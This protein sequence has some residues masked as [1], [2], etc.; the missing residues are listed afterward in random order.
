MCPPCAKAQMYTAGHC[1]LCRAICGA[2]RAGKGA[3]APGLGAARGEGGQEGWVYFCL[4]C[5]PMSAIPGCWQAIQSCPH[6]SK[7]PRL[8][9][10]SQV[11]SA[12][13]VIF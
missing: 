10:K 3:A 9:W 6:I 12:H 4:L 2:E 8:A 5:P 1:H 11:M 7:G 13:E